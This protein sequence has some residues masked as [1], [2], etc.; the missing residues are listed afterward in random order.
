MPLV[1][2]KSDLI[3]AR[4]EGYAVPLFN[5]FDPIAVDGVVAAIQAKNAPCILGVYSGCFK[6]ENIEA[7]AAYIR[8]R[9]KN[10]PMPV[11]LMLDHG[12][13]A[14]QARKAIE[15]GFT[16]VMFDGSRL[17]IAENAD[18]TR[19]IIQ[20]ARPH[21]VGVEAEIGHVGQGSEYGDID[22]KRLGFTDP[23][24]AQLFIE[25]TGVDFLAIAFGNAHGEYKGE[26]HID[27]GLLSQIASRTGIP[28]VMHGGSGLEDDQYRAVARCGI[29]KINYFTGINKV[30]TEK[31]VE[32]ANS[33][34]PAMFEMTA[35]LRLAYTDLGSHYLEVFG[36]AGKAVEVASAIAVE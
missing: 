17:P 36:A 31:M 33:Q 20:F 3:R 2:I 32:A 16:D 8:T 22:S 30:A 25:Q 19:Q 13:S 6:D 11:S 4:R 12:E 14:D 1:S 5:V 35:A 34:K 9:V 28:L 7:F 10:L 15:L 26:P 18:I 21:G 24:A 29:A 27:M 23:A